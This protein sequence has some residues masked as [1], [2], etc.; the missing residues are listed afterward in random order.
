MVRYPGYRNMAAFGFQRGKGP[1]GKPN[2]A[3]GCD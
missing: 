2:P 1:I 3:A